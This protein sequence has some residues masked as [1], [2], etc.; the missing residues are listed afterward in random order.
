[1]QAHS[2]YLLFIVSGSCGKADL[3]SQT[4]CILRSKGLVSVND[5]ITC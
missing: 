4:A 1:M 3:V 5:I 2:D